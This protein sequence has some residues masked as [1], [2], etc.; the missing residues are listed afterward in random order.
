MPTFKTREGCGAGAV[1]VLESV[2]SGS[3]I[4]GGGAEVFAE[5]RPD[6]ANEIE[7]PVKRKH[8]NT[9]EIEDRESAGA[10]DMRLLRERAVGRIVA[11]ARVILMLDLLHCDH[12]TGT[13]KFDFTDYYSSAR[14]GSRDSFV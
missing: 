1:V 9:H 13:K 7:T 10:D 6:W 4:G 11:L 3:V 8:T 2:D 14:S 12:N 5:R